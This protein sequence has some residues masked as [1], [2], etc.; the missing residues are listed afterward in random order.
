[1]NRFPTAM[2]IA[3]G[4]ELNNRL[5]PALYKLRDVIADKAKK[6]SAVVKIGRTHLQVRN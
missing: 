3:A 2:H 4:L 1:M 6:F 5:L